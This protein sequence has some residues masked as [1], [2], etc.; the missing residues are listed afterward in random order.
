MGSVADV[1][2]KAL[3]N[4]IQNLRYLGPNRLHCFY[5]TGFYEICVRAPF[6][7]FVL[8]VRSADI[9]ED[10]RSS[11]PSVAYQPRGS[12]CYIYLYIYIS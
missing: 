1:V 9:R 4:D 3:R 12:L 7:T 6:V 11:V 10:I 8:D 2:S 5:D